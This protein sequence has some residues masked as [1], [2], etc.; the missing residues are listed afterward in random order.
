MIRQ[1]TL[2]KPFHSTGCYHGNMGITSLRTQTVRNKFKG[3]NNYNRWSQQSL[4][5][6]L[7]E[8]MNLEKVLSLTLALVAKILQNIFRPTDLYDIRAFL[9][10]KTDLYMHDIRKRILLVFL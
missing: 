2:V 8:P 7:L 9:E 6:E 3:W 1:F 10:P 5:L 4:L